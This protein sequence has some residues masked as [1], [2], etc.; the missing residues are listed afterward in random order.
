MSCTKSTKVKRLAIRET[1]R[2]NYLPTTQHAVD[3]IE[4]YFF[5]LDHIGALLKQAK[6]AVKAAN[7]TVNSDTA[8]LR[9]VS[10]ELDNIKIPS[11]E[12]DVD[13]I[14]NSINETCET[15]QIFQKNI[16][17]CI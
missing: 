14:L 8:R 3:L 7:K 11:G 9:N 6:D 13:N 17:I 4:M 1:F 2:F 15:L 12:T 10:E 5:Y 16:S